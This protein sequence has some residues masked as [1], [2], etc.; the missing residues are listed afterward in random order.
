M[1]IAIVATGSTAEIREPNAKLEEEKRKGSF[2]MLYHSAHKINSK[3]RDCTWYNMLVH[4][5]AEVTTGEGVF[6]PT[7]GICWQTLCQRQ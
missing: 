4:T 6:S 3:A 5:G 7:Y 2:R 1:K